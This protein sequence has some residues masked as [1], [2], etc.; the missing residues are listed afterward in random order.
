MLELSLS[1]AEVQTIID[2][3]CRA[4]D[5]GRR[6]SATTARGLGGFKEAWNEYLRF[7]S[8]GVD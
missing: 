6:S 4:E 7:L 3:L 8:E 1:V 2:D 5:A